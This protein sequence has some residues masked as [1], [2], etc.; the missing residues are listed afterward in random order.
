[1]PDEAT[2]AKVGFTPGHPRFGGKKKGNASRVRDLVEQLGPSSDPL[3]FLLLLIRDKTYQSVVIDAD[4]KKKKVIVAAPLDLII[5]AC[6]TT[7]QYLVP[8]LSSIAVGGGPDGDGPI[9]TVSLNLTA[10][11]QNPELARQAQNIALVALRTPQLP[12]PAP[13]E[14]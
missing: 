8:K 12:A 13:E 3:R 1:M 9:E 2:P 10:I 7:A 14:Q 4:G 11:M 6:K 5:D